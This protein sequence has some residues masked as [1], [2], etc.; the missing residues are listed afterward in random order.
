MEKLKIKS[1]NDLDSYV[2]SQSI[3]MAAEI[4]TDFEKCLE[5]S[6]ECRKIYHTRLSNGNL[7]TSADSGINW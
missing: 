4:L 2:K 6:Y 7:Q 5:K 1:F 3:E